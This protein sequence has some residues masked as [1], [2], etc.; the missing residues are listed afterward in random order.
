MYLLKKIE[1]ILVVGPLADKPHEQMGTWVFDGEASH[2]QTP[3]LALRKQYGEKVKIDYE[4]VLKY[5][6]DND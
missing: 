2:T 3:L 1:K 5:S 4:P 6:R